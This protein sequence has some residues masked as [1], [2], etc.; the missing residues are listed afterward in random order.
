M[1]KGKIKFYVALFALFFV[2][3][4]CGKEEITVEDYVRT[5]PS[6]KGMN[7]IMKSDTGYY[8]TTTSTSNSGEKYD[9]I[10]YFD[11]ASGQNIYL[12][13]KPECRHNGD[14]FC[15]ATSGKY[16]IHGSY[17]YDGSLYLSVV[18]ATGEEYLFKLL[19]V[20]ADGSE[21][22]EVVT[23]Y[24]INTTSVMSL[25]GGEQMLIHRGVAVLPY[26]LINKEALGS[27]GTI[28][29]IMG[30]CLYN[31][32]TG[33]LTELPE[34]ESSELMGGRERF[35]GYGDY[36]YYNAKTDRTNTLSRYCLID[37]TVE[38]LELSRTYVGI[39]EVIDE[40]TIYYYYLGNRLFEYKIST[41]ENTFHKDVFVDN[42]EKYIPSIDLVVSS[43][44]DYECTDMVTDGTYLYAGDGVDFHTMQ[45]GHFGY[46]TYS[47]G[48]QVEQKN[49]VHVYDKDLAEVARVEISTKTYLDDFVRFSLAILDDTVYMQTQ[50]MVLACT[51]EDFL[52]GGQPPFEPLYVHQD[53]SYLDMDQ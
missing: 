8:Y 3:A 30:T 49:Y 7:G 52:K 5:N 37:G 39:Y 34:I 38:E 20:S 53:I 13:C 31:L 40:D 21:L 46:D 27:T 16:N 29:S 25:V 22:T 18:E 26:Y 28:V 48:S 24:R 9:A 1:M 4:G 14:E 6:T 32:A 19:R 15:T 11:E 10:H 35:T 44:E 2:L 36:I 47:D 42:C 23:F 43:S 33:E 45:K 17:F 50:S 12:C 51:L 41:K